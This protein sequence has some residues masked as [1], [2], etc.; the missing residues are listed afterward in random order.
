MQRGS[1]TAEL[2]VAM[3]AVVIVIGAV[4]AVGAVVGAQ[5]RCIDAARV[6]ARAAARGEPAGRTLAAAR[7]AGPPG[8]LVELGRSGQ[9][10]VVTT[11]V[12]VELP[13]PGHPSLLVSGRAVAALEPGLAAVP[14]RLAHCERGSASPV[15][16]ATAILALLLASGSAA[17]GQAV[18]ARHVA[19]SA[20]DLAALAAAGDPAAGFAPAAGCGRG[21]WVAA[22]NGA[23]LT[24][25]RAGG[26]G[27][28]TVDVAVRLPGALGALGPAVARARAGRSAVVP[29]PGRS[30]AVERGAV[31]QGAEQASGGRLVERVVAVAALG[32][33]HA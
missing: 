15:V 22:A 9:D 10:V 7:Q 31:E 1:A 23:R 3:P 2:A 11:R 28:V 18:R 17:L 32:G 19:E 16:L 14:S 4:L 24:A 26:D 6:A 20:A 21:A 27:S 13:L 5:V 30:G 25:C 8:V 33:L 12:R 29:G